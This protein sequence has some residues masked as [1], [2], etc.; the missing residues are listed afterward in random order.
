MA[1]DLSSEVDVYWTTVSYLI[2]AFY[3]I[4]SNPA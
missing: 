2:E 1:Q 4:S 3:S